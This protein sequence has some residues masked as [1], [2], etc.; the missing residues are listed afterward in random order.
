[1][2][3][4]K[5]LISAGGGIVSPFQQ[6]E[7]SIDTGNILIG[8]GGT[9][10]DCIRSIKT[11][12]HT[13]IKPDGI[14]VE[15]NTYSRIRFLGVDSD[16]HSC[17]RCEDGTGRNENLP[18]EDKEFLFIG[19]KNVSIPIQIQRSPELS[20]FNYEN[21]N[22]PPYLDRGACGI[23]QVGRLL[24]M[25]HSQLFI[26][27]IEKEIND[28]QNGTYNSRVNIHIFAGLSGGTGSGCF[29]DV[30]YM[31]RSIAER[32]GEVTIFGYFLLPDVHL[33]IVPFTNVH[34]R[35]HIMK[36]GYAAMQEL[37]YCMT[38]P[39]NGG[40]FEQEYQE[41]RWISWNR[42][43]V[44]MCHVISSMDVNGHIHGCADSYGY[45][46]TLDAITEHVMQFL[47]DSCPMTNLA[48][49]FK[50]LNSQK[51]IGAQMSYCLI[52]GVCAS[53]P[54]RKINTYFAAQLFNQFAIVQR[55]VPSREDVERL[56]ILSLAQGA[57]SLSAIYESLFHELLEDACYEPYD[58]AGLA[59]AI[60]R[61]EELYT[62]QTFIKC[63]KI[64]KNAENMMSKSNPQSLFNRI[65]EQLILILR[66]IDKGPMFAYRMLSSSESHNLLNVIN[67]LIEEN[68]VR[69][70]QEDAQAELKYS[71][72]ET[73]KNDFSNRRRRN[74]FDNDSKRFKDCEF[75]IM[76][77]EQHRLNWHAYSYMDQVLRTFRNQ[78]V[79]IT[80]SY[81][82]KLNRVMDTLINTFAE[83]L[84]ALESKKY[85]EENRPFA[86]SL[87]TIAELKKFLDMQI[88]RINISAVLDLFMLS[89]VQNEDEWIQEDEN[90]IVRFVT[91]F[92]V[93]TV[94]CG[95]SCKTV[96]SF[97]HEKYENKHGGK[98]TD[99][100][101]A[102]FIYKDMLTPLTKIASPL[103][104]FNTEIWSEEQTIR[105]WCIVVPSDSEPIKAAAKKMHNEN[106]LWG[107]KESK[108]TD[109]IYIMRSACGFPLSS[110]KNCT[111]YERGFFMS[112][113]P[114]L[115]SYE[116]KAVHGMDLTDWNM[117]PSV[118][119]QSVVDIDH[120][121]EDLARLIKEANNLY[122]R[123]LSLGV[124]DNEGYLYEA[125]E[126]RLAC[127]N[128][129]CNSCEIS[130][131]KTR[132]EQDASML[133]QKVENI[134]ELLRI[135]MIKI[136]K[137]LPSDGYR[138]T[139][140]LIFN[141]Q[142]DYFFA[143]PALHATV[144]EK[145]ELVEKMVKRADSIIKAAE[146]KI[147]FRVTYD[148]QLHDFCEALLTGVI[149]I[150]GRIIAYKR[151]INGS[152]KTIILN[153]RGEGYPFNNIPLYQGF[154]SYQKLENDVKCEVKKLVEE[155][156][157]VGAPEIYSIGGELKKSLS[158]ERFAAFGQLAS[159]V[160]EAKEC[161]DIIAFLSDIK[162]EMD[163]FF[164]KRGI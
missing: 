103:F 128:T 112:K 118:T 52:G 90:K 121:P 88:E 12:V 2:V 30:C 45:G 159:L 83:N 143:S 119:P 8:L 46:N 160:Y 157:N 154:L 73:A 4:K 110:Y 117:L 114:G 11:Q 104:C 67:G 19:V 47:V 102:E 42:P 70:N 78:I 76:A 20:W 91:D 60:D 54:L 107:V 106:Y 140:E 3:Y 142:K 49:A 80:S 63:Q 22:I 15:G 93:N 57:Q 82:N 149:A 152:E 81:Y 50:C 120:A 43:P 100:Q 135:P 51:R 158:N 26:K 138:I 7:Q 151:V 116:G 139:K 87:V 61:L 48:G 18:L 66:D 115:H 153:K 40:S 38:L 136:C 71:K 64:D 35:S 79:E 124:L 137:L 59:P 123:A 162:R 53:I 9:G 144:R 23:R 147:Q 86:I 34:V 111:D 25:E 36:N 31:V 14:S 41:K 21:I 127:L 133:R 122:E 65:H 72:Y 150:D 29:L 130:T 28:V 10:I 32:I 148:R 109:S 94:F 75:Y 92:F 146:E 131:A 62:H 13:R 98:I 163:D 126:T 17:G 108:F 89:L 33:S 161:S 56:A 84:D 85:V 141:I 55:N 99:E 113:E 58:F 39:E 77:L 16:V 5:L 68:C 129:A 145:I 134:R 24:M 27:K 132:N 155:R 164:Y 156:L 125:D 69:W 44:D 101:L 96:T 37:D 74:L 6:V 1:M 95:F 97:L 105:D